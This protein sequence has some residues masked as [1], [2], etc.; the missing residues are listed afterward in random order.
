[1][2]HTCCVE[3][4]P[5]VG[6]VVVD[7]PQRPL[8]ALKL[9]RGNLV[10]RGHLDGVKVLRSRAEVQHASPPSVVVVL[11][12]KR[13]NP[14]LAP[15]RVGLGPFGPSQPNLRPARF[16]GPP[17]SLDPTYVRSTHVPSTVREWP[18]NSA[19]T[20][21]SA[22]LTDT[23]YMPPRPARARSAHSAMRRSPGR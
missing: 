22:R 17:L 12:A 15:G 8:Q 16:A 18:R 23:S 5:V 21:P 6:H 11:D 19:I 1:G 10:A 20:V 7:V 13:R 4:L 9:Q 14:T 3:L 2:V